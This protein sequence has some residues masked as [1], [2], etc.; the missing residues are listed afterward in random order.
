MIEMK[1]CFLSCQCFDRNGVIRDDAASLVTMTMLRCFVRMIA[2]TGPEDITAAFQELKISSLGD[3]ISWLSKHVLVQVGPAAEKL[4]RTERHEVPA[5]H[6]TALCWLCEQCSVA[7]ACEHMYAV[8]LHEGMLSK[9]TPW[10]KEKKRRRVAGT[11][12]QPASSR[13]RSD[14][15]AAP[16]PRARSFKLSSTFLKCLEKH[17]L[18]NFRPAFEQHELCEKELAHWSVAA[19]V[20]LIQCPAGRMR[21]FLADILTMKQQAEEPA[22]KPRSHVFLEF[23][24]P[25]LF[26]HFLAGCGFITCGQHG[27]TRCTEQ[28]SPW[29]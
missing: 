20:E 12:V 17:D 14:A 11:S 10:K 9:N 24:L 18:M 29:S 1:S 27:L 4:W 15:V 5:P 16:S 23:L 6:H 22:E 13:A 2:A 21:R 28:R 8:W 3:V 25:T 19:L 7:G 26:S